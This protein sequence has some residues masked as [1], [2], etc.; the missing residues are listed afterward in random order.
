MRQRASVLI[1]E[2]RLGTRTFLEL[3]LGQEGLRVF[4][5]V[6]LNSALLQ[7]RTLRPDLIII[8]PGWQELG[9]G[10][11]EARIKAVSAAPLLV[12]GNGAGATP[13]PGRAEPAPLPLN[14][15]ELCARVAQALGGQCESGPR[16]TNSS[17]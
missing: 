16:S 9:E 10:G 4:S 6:S 12:L 11:A 15:G 7:L 17:V 5:A 2:S 8:G 1:V 13:G 3:T 14:P